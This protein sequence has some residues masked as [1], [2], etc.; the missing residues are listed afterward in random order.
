MSFLMCLMFELHSSLSATHLGRL[1]A[2]PWAPSIGAGGKFKPFKPKCSKPIT[3]VPTNEN[4]EQNQLSPLTSVL[5]G[6]WPD[7]FSLGNYFIVYSLSKKLCFAALSAFVSFFPI[8]ISSC[9]EVCVHVGW[10]VLPDIQ[11]GIPGPQIH[12]YYIFYFT[13]LL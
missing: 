13:T 4:K 10:G 2:R 1:I 8:F 3:L 12:F 6:T 9:G 7:H 5:H 11:Q